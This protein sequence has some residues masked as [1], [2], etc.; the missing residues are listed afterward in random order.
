[1]ERKKPRIVNTKLKE[2]SKFGGLTP[3]D[4]KTYYKAAY[5]DVW[6][7]WRIDTQISRTE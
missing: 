5:Q 2:K 3:A 6:Y 7:W 4:F 1:M